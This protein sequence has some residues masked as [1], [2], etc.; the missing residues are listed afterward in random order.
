MKKKLPI[1]NYPW[2]FWITI[3]W[4]P[5]WFSFYWTIRGANFRDVQLWKLHISIGRPWLQVLMDSHQR[6]YGSAKDIHETNKGN[7]R[8]RFSILLKPP[9]P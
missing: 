3:R 4:R 8:N 2:V 7:L 6:D 9:K 5:E 1:S